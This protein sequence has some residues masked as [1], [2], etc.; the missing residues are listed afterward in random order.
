[1]RSPPNENASET[2]KIHMPI[3]PGVAAPYCASG[4][5]VAGTCPW[6]AV[7]VMASLPP[8]ALALRMRLS[9]EAV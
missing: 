8:G 5:Q 4:G 2:R 3:F 6:I 7:D 9:A 1:M